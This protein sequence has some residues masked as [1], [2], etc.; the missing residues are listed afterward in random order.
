M[1]SAKPVYLLDF[2]PDDWRE[3]V[4]PHV[5][6]AVVA[7]LSSFVVEEYR[8]GTVYPRKQDIYAAYRLCPL[9]ATRG[10]VERMLS[11]S[12]ST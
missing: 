9:A 10:V 8:S 12:A 3:A 2:M 4:A 7:A 5:D 1:T 6:P 11:A